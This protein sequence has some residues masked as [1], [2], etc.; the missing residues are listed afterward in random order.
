MVGGGKPAS[1]EVVLLG[2][3]VPIVHTER[4]G[5]ATLVKY[6]TWKEERDERIIFE[7]RANLDAFK[8]IVHEISGDGEVLFEDPSGL[9]VTAIEVDHRPVEPAYGFKFASPDGTLVLSGDTCKCPNLLEAAKGADALVH[10]VFIARE[11]HAR[12]PPPWLDEDTFHLFSPKDSQTNIQGYHTLDDE[13][14]KIA[15]EAGVGMLVLTHLVPPDPDKA[16]LLEV[17]GQDYSGP[18]VVGEDLMTINVT[19]RTV[20][21][22]QGWVSFGKWVK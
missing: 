13:V 9:V 4:Y 16:K 20:S 6:K 14:G 12:P 11:I 17:V 7:K 1:L 18:I 8:I 3:G 22:K 2:T 19:A 15:N 21:H 10:E 5:A